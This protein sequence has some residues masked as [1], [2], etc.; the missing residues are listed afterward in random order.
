MQQRNGL[1]MQ[2]CRT[3]QPDYTTIPTGNI[4][5]APELGTPRYNG[6][7]VGSQWSM[8]VRMDSLGCIMLTLSTTTGLSFCIR[9]LQQEDG[10]V[11]LLLAWESTS[12]LWIPP[13]TMGHID[14]FFQVRT[15]SQVHCILEAIRCTSQEEFEWPKKWQL[16]TG[17]WR[18]VNSDLV[19]S[20]SDRL[21][22]CDVCVHAVIPSKPEQWSSF[23]TESIHDSLSN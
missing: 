22:C 15:V 11:Q 23:H 5:E 20:V 10:V 7:N 3:Q 1:K 13:S 6:W 9:S 18:T 14:D 19:Y 8:S 4:L 21:T 16:C 17:I 12:L 2:P